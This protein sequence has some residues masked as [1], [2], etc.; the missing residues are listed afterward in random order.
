MEE[1]GA[2][3]EGLLRHIGMEERVLFPTLR[4]LHGATVDDVLARL[5]LDHGAIVSLLVPP[6]RAMVVQALRRVLGAHNH[7]EE[8]PGGVYSLCD[9]I[10]P[11]QTAG[12]LERLRTT[13]KVPVKA[14]NDAPIAMASARRALTLA[15]Y[16][17]AEVL[18]DKVGA[19][20]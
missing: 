14:F 15:G 4:E 17:P 7:S 18:G 1:Y 6:P 2:F 16:D 10:G 8:K 13:P 5:R 11:A 3:R 19:E 20:P 9:A 12:M